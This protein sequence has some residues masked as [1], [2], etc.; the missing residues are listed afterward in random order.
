MLARCRSAR[1]RR[2]L[3]WSA[4]A[5]ARRSRRAP[6]LQLVAECGDANALLA[7]I[8][9]E[10]QPRSRR[11]RHPDGR[12]PTPTR[13]SGWPP[14]SR[15][16]PRSGRGPASVLRAR[17]T[18]CAAVRPGSDGKG[19]LLVKEPSMTRARARRRDPGRRLG[20]SGHRPEVVEVLVRRRRGRAH[21]RWGADAARARG[22]R[23]IA[24]G[25]SNPRSPRVGADQAR[26]REAHQ[27]DL[28]E[29]QPPARTRWPRTSAAR[30]GGAR[31]RRGRRRVAARERGSVISGNPGARHCRPAWARPQS[32]YNPHEERR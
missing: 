9:R 11:T 27:R 20:W 15:A 24:E 32:C 14:G 6:Q 7:E 22:A 10:L 23:A 17:S 4:R 29:A 18:C 12:R 3:F 21:P 30:E 25:K 26:C 1:P 19:V 28:P 8:G 13:G 16:H 5:C 2:Q 31:P